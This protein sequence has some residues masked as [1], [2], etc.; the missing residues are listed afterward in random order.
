MPYEDDGYNKTTEQEYIRAKEEEFA[1]LFD[2]VNNSISD[3]VWQWFKNLIYE[4]MEIETLNETA[5]EMMA[6]STASGVFLDK[7]GEECGILRKGA[8]KSQGYVEVTR[9]ITGAPFEVPER[10]RFKSLTN[11][12]E[13]DDINYIPYIIRLTKSKTGESDD[14]YP[15][16]IQSTATIVQIRDTNNQLIDRSYY[17][18][19]DSY[20]NNIQWTASSSAV[21]V[22]DEEYDVYVSGEVVKRIEVSSELTGPGTKGSINTVNICLDFPKLVTNNAEEIDG[23]ADEESDEPY[24]TRL[25][26]ARRRDFTLDRIKSII[27]GLEGVRAVKVYQ[28][29]GTDQTSVADWDNPSLGTTIQVS[30]TTSIYSQCFVPGDQI[31]TLGKITLRGQPINDPPAIY[32]GVKGN[33]DS[34]ATGEMFDYNYIEKYELDQSV[35]GTRDITIPVKWNNMDKTKTY[36][37]DV[38]CKDPENPTFDWVTHH[39]ELST[40]TEQYRTDSRGMLKK[41]VDGSWVDQGNNLDLM[42]KTRF[43][44]AGFNVV[45]AVDDGYGYLNIYDKVVDY[46]DYVEQGGFSPVCI[47]SVITEAEEVLIDVKAVLYITTLADFQNVRREVAE[48]LESYLESLVVGDNVVYSRIYQT[49]MNHS[50][51]SKLE[52]LYIKRSESA[53]WFERDLGVLDSEIPDLGT[54]TFQRG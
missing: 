8:T 11:T 19:D 37:F 7:W 33:I 38:W 32:I 53:T 45:L 49:I 16:D 34:V 27:L 48:D 54:R 41:M 24:R 22:K 26:E 42:F 18:L 20:H 9:I 17:V 10:T 51:V 30:G 25:L 36:R 31:A 2:V 40:S 4:R 3:V 12:Y 52:E 29:V 21:I 35:S 39:W 50:Q 15:T 14:Y 28:S 23:G 43:N 5:A 44:G 46:L 6:I 47:Q 13:A 1:D